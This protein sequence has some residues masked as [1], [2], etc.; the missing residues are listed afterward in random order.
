[1][2]VLGHDHVSDDGEVISSAPTADWA[3]TNAGQAAQGRLTTESFRDYPFFGFFG[4]P[5]F[6]PHLESSLRCLRLVAVPPF[7]PIHRGQII[8]VRGCHGQYV[9]L[10]TA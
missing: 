2:G 5:P 3:L 10:A 6:L 7:L 4:R 8:R 9:S 1:M